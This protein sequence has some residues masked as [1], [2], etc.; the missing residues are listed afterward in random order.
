MK[1]LFIGN[2]ATHY[3]DMPTAIFAPMCEAAGYDVEVTAITKGGYH[4]AGHV[5]QNDPVGKLVHTALRETKYD[6]VIMQDYVHTTVPA[7]YYTSVRTL[8]RMVRKNG[9]IP[10][11]YSVIPPLE[12][13]EGT[14]GKDFGYGQN[15]KSF[16]YKSDSASRAIAAELGIGVAHAGLA[17]FHLMETHPE[18]NL[19][20]SDKRHPGALGSFVI[21][22]TIFA[23]VFNH[24]PTKVDFIG[25]TDA[26][27]AAIL[28]EAARKYTFD[29][30]EIP[31]E[32]DMG[33]SAGVGV[34]PNRNRK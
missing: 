2:S 9:A 7:D 5:N 14:Y 21:A 16:A 34:V 31:P 4:L 28:K 20:H 13:A 11:L 15:E 24:D 26:E 22:S 8:T 3:N 23:T 18:L 29:L 32:Y 19:H 33:A 12:A 1:I 25:S 17:V 6:Y 30:P 27:T 10:I